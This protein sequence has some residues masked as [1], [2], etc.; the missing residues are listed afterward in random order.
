VAGLVGAL[1]VVRVRRAII[2][3][4]KETRPSVAA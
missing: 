1:M 3:P 2:V 4:S